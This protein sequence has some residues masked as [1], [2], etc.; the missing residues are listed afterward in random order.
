MGELARAPAAEITGTGTTA[1][2]LSER[3]ENDT[4]PAAVHQ[5]GGFL[6]SSVNGQAREIS[7]YLRRRR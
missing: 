5:R 4:S 6:L 7:R 1:S 3:D 2:A